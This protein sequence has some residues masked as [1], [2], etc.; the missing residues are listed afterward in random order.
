M[1][2]RPQKDTYTHGHHASVVAQHSR[3]TA[4]EAA[5]FLLPKLRPGMRLLD[6]LVAA[7]V[8]SPPGS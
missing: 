7:P 4:E 8:R 5:A 2:E 1:S 3:R 6:A